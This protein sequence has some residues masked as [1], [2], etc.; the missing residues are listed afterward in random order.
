VCSHERHAPSARPAQLHSAQLVRLTHTAMDRDGRRPG[1]PPGWDRGRAPA[2]GA[3][4]PAV[5]RKVCILFTV[6]DWW[7][8]RLLCCASACSNS[9]QALDDMPGP[10]WGREGPPPQRGV[11]QRPPP[12][13]SIAHVLQLWHLLTTLLLTNDRGR[14][15]VVVQHP[16]TDGTRV[17]ELTPFGLCHRVSLPRAS[18]R[19][20]AVVSLQLM[21]VT[22]YLSVFVLSILH[23]GSATTARPT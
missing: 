3:F 6:E 18:T 15:H 7:H 10:P 20:L 19:S 5:R 21:T 14:L 23:Q 9:T 1:P 13:P 4:G 12:T 22:Q 8:L 2:G 17:R 11:R 16:S